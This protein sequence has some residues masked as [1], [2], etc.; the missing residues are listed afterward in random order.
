MCGMKPE[1]TLRSVV[2]PEPVPP[3]TTMF[4]RS[5]T[6]TR[7][8]PAIASVHVPIRTKSSAVST[9]LANLRMVTHGPMSESG[10]MMAFTRLPSRRRAST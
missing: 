2:L 9:R 3:A 6:Q 10:G 1:R 5:S 7:R 8:K 4:L